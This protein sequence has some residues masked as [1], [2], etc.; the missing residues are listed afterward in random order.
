MERRSLSWEKWKDPKASNPG[1]IAEYA[2]ANRLVEEPAFKWWIH[3]S[4]G[5]GTES[6][7]KAS[8]GIDR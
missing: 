4:C 2:V 1:K 6:F 5:D 7:R 8:R 3:L